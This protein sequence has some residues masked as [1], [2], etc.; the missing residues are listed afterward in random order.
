MWD[1]AT[2]TCKF[3]MSGHTGPVCGLQFQ[4]NHL[5][6]VAKEDCIRVWNTD[7]RACV[8]MLDEQKYVTGVQ[9][10]TGR[11]VSWSDLNGTLTLWDRIQAPPMTAQVVAPL[12]QA[13]VLAQ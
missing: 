2:G 3:E 13:Q 1:L 10:Q 6:S 11:L 9:F 4:N 12:P 8:R 5:L 7:Q